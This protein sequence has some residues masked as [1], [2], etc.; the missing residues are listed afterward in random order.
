M[1]RRR[2]LHRLPAQTLEL[3]ELAR[4]LCCLARARERDGQRIVRLVAIRLHREGAAQRRDR[5]LR[6]FS[7]QEHLAHG[8]QHVG[9]VWC[10][11][12][13]CHQLGERVLEP[14]GGHKGG[15]ELAAEDWIVGTEPNSV[16]E[17]V[18]RGIQL[19]FDLSQPRDSHVQGVPARQRA[20]EGGDVFA[21]GVRQ[22]PFPF[23][24]PSARDPRDGRIVRA[25]R[26]AAVPAG[27][28]GAV[29][30]CGHRLIESAGGQSRK[31]ASKPGLSCDRGP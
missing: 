18:D 23:S 7:V 4:G 13:R 25:G 1:T 30:Q 24:G 16:L 31:H 22:P 5:L 3:L 6:A 29:P 8:R 27:R 15:G 20:L 28:R 21:A 14:A 26:R 17:R 10:D 12:Q 11:E 19:P 9:L 2:V